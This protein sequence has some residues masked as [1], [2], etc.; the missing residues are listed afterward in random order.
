MTR[1]RQLCDRLWD[2]YVAR[3]PHP[4]EWYHIERKRSEPK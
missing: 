4:P 1:L 3:P 2:R